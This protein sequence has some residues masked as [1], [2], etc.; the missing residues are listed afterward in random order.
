MP[1]QTDWI[2]QPVD[3]PVED[4]MPSGTV[5]LFSKGATTN[6]KLQ[7]EGSGSPFTDPRQ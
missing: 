1:G 4:P 3:L 7:V 5:H 6:V 2:P